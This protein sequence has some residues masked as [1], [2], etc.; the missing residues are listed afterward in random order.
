M[1]P[2]AKRIREYAGQ[3]AVTLKELC[4]RSHIGDSTI[5][6]S[7]KSK[8]QLSLRITEDFCEANGIPLWAFFFPDF[9]D[10]QRAAR[11]T[12]LISALLTA[13]DLPALPDQPHDAVREE[14][15]GQVYG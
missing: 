4:R 10:P 3:Y 13:E 11:L 5:R 1:F 7:E 8:H 14:K 6:N 9:V 12:P 15:P 2:A